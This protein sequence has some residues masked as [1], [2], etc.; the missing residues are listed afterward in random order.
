MGKKG[1]EKEGARRELKQAKEK[2]GTHE[3]A[4][5]GRTRGHGGR[6]RAAIRKVGGI[7]RGDRRRE[8]KKRKV[9]KI[10]YLLIRGAQGEGSFSHSTNA[11]EQEKEKVTLKP[12]KSP[13]P[14]V[15]KKTRVGFFREKK[16]GESS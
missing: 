1:K 7:K 8:K 13:A 14:K 6:T 4:G 12:C 3:T 15:K 11:A 9:K 5:S 2:K 16:K 10:G